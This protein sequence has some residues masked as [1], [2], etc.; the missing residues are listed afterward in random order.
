LLA[1]SA[2][3][4]PTT[5]SATTAK[6]VAANEQPSQV[7]LDSIKQARQQGDLSRADQLAQQYLQKASVSGDTTEQAL[8][9]QVLG[10]NAMERNEHRQAQQW[11]T[12]A[13]QLLE[14]TEQPLLF[15][16]ALRL[17][18]MNYRYQDDHQQALTL[19]YRALQLFQQLGD[20][21]EIAATQGSIGT[22]LDRLG[23]Y[24]AALQA[25]QQQ[26]ELYYQLG[27]QDKI[28][29]VIFN[30]GSLN[31]NLG[32]QAQALQYFLQALALDEA[33]GDVRDMAYSHNKLAYLY[34]ELGEFAKSSEHVTKALQGFAQVGAARDL[35]WARSVAAKL[36][37]E[38]E[39][40]TKASQLLDGIIERARTGQYHS[41]LV[42]ACL[43]AAEVAV[44]QQ[45][46]AQAVPYLMEGIAEAKRQHLPAD[47]ALL[48]KLQV[49]VYLRLGQSAAALIALQRQKQLEDDIFNHKRAAAIAALQAQ[50]EYSRQQHQLLVLQKDQ[51]LSQAM[52]ERQ[53]AERR[54]LIAGV[55]AFALLMFS[56]Y[57]RLVQRQQNRMLEREVSARTLELQQKNQQLQDAYVQLEQISLTDQLTGLSNRHFLEQ[58]IDAEL[59]QCRRRW[60]DRHLAMPAGAVDVEPAEL[61]V[62]IVD[63]DHFKQLNDRYGHP[64]G[65][66]VLQQMKARLLQVFR[67]SDYLVRW[68]GEE[69]VV[70]ARQIRREDAASLAERLV[71]Q[72]RSSA[73]V[74]PDG[75]T[76]R[77][78][79]SVGYVCYPQ[80]LGDSAQHWPLLLQ[81]ADLC[82]YGAKASGRDGWVGL[83]QLDDS[84]ASQAPFNCSLLQ[85]W[86]QQGQLQLQ[87]SARQ[88]CWPA[89][90]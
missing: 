77:V 61:A 81:L 48:L 18:G 55:A 50:T 35:D 68:G 59:L 37:M 42:D 41:L 38:Q 9:Y 52:L 90:S 76:L 11:L 75:N 20:Q 28:P 16:R 32:E 5:V 8:A 10:Q 34:A 17:L 44:R 60:Q 26:L 65:D 4:S 13:V 36:A 53:Q 46:D 49:Q 88:L 70:V 54:Y 56:L 39:E 79:C 62:F 6:P 64:A 43:L 27:A 51:A 87:H 23:L 57:R 80:L 63:L 74:L 15:G 3:A 78:S 29:S 45:Q 89:T 85:H 30:L 19:L 33:S 69:F 71:Q 25:Y 82:L 58:Q 73:F 86:Q 12:Q 1:C 66:A 84:L 14:H 31:R 40:Y 24:E 2:T 22:A 67:Q 7:L 72:V 47:E 21:A 83:A